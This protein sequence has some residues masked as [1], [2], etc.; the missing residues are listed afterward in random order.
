MEL[1]N[2]TGTALELHEINP[3]NDDDAQSETND[4]DYDDTILR[5]GEF[6]VF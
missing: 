3:S 4:D 6:A 5:K 2:R 1:G